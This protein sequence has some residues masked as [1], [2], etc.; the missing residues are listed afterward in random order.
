MGR[1]L[2][3]ATRYVCIAVTLLSGCQSRQKFTF[4]QGIQAYESVATKIEY[5]DTS[6]PPESQLDTADAPRTLRHPGQQQTWELTLDEAI[7]LTLANSRVMRQIGGRIVGS[8]NSSSTVFDAALSESEPRFGPE[9]ALADFDAQFNSGIVFN[10][11][12]R[13]LNSLFFG[14]GTNSLAQNKGLF[15]AEISKITATGTAFAIR[16]YTDY[17]R[18]NAPSNLFPSAYNTAFEAEFRQPFFQGAGLEFN[19]IAGPRSSP[20]NYRGVLIARTNTDIALADFEVG[21]RDMLHAVQRAYWQ[22]YFSYRD[23]DAKIAARDF[24]LQTWRVE[25]ERREAGTGEADREPL[26]REQYFIAQAQVEDALGGTATS[27]LVVGTTAGIYTAERQLRQL[28]GLSVNDGRLIRPADEPAAVEIIFDWNAAISESLWRRVE[29]RR[30]LW[31]IK[32]REMELT[33][34]KNF[35]QVRVDFVGKYNWHGFGDHFTGDAEFSNNSAFQDL[36]DGDL[37][38]WELGLQMST[39]IGNRIAHTAVRHAEL[40]L[41]REK[42]VY[43]EQELQI[44]HE[45]ASAF[46]ELD[47]SY[48]VS[49]TNFNRRIAAYNRLQVIRARYEAGEALLEFVL[50]ALRAASEAD[51]AY[52]RTLVNYNLA[53]TH[54]HLN[55]GTLLASLN[56]HLEEGAWTATAHRSAA[57]QSRRFLPKNM[58]YSLSPHRIISKGAFP[59]SMPTPLP[60]VS[61]DP[62][63][64]TLKSDTSAPRI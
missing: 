5:P 62:T 59:Q 37:Q 54:L 17:D 22:L 52:F 40:Q 47:R 34:A 10:R 12:E 43:H 50:D 60:T 19:R 55:K 3:H 35:R 1:Q 24:A 4:D 6:C 26:A 48:T 56:V 61:A 9:A 15:N 16:H 58:N 32:R 36:F 63:D 57:K 8:P 2:A 53:I 13:S 28:I 7:Q 27:G 11:T 31:M 51:S 23:L 44:S 30:Q 42:S 29:L 18:N 41:V 45:L 46:A 14:G 20:G 33:A 25:K 21:V 39:P 38:D 49:R 64:P